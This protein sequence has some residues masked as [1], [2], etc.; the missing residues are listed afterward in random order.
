[1]AELV[2]VLAT[3]RG[4]GEPANQNNVASE[5]DHAQHTY[6][7]S[8]S[9]R[10]RLVPGRQSISPATREDIRDGDS[11]AREAETEAQGADTDRHRPQAQAQVQAPR[12]VL[13]PGRQ[14]G[15]QLALSRRVA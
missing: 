13:W 10:V 8:A 5:H 1:M 4:P 12:R 3:Y 14:A 15:R 2:A 9:G 11:R 7:M 6:P